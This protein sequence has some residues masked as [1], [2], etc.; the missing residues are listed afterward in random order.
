MK[1]KLLPIISGILFTTATM[2]SCLKSDTP[3]FE[4]IPDATI[5]AFQIDTV[6]GGI[7]KPFSIN[8]KAGLIFN[9]DSLPFGSDTVINKILIKE[10]KVNYTAV[11]KNDSILDLRDSLDLTKPLELTTK[12][13][14]DTNYTKKYTIKVNVHKQ[15][16]NSIDWSTI[17]ASLPIG[18]EETKFLANIKN[19][20]MAFSKSGK[21][22]TLENYKGNWKPVNT[23]DIGDSNTIV[24]VITTNDEK[25]IALTSNNKL[26]ISED[27]EAWTSS[28]KEL[29]NLLG[30]NKEEIFATN[31]NTLHYGSIQNGT[32]EWKE[33]GNTPKDF[34]V[35][36]ITSTTYQLNS[37][38]TMLYGEIESDQTAP[39]VWMYQKEGSWVKTA[40]AGV[41]KNSLPRLQNPTIF[42][43]NNM[44]YVLG[45]VKVIIKK[46]TEEKTTKEEGKEEETITKY[47]N[48]IYTSQDA[49]NWYIANSK[50]QIP[51]KLEEQ[52]IETLTVDNNNYIWFITKDDNKVWRGRLNKLG[53]K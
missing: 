28:E 26:Y 1:I 39:S 38:L 35:K 27:G 18:A 3:N 7:T 53:F 9:P 45:K 23:F 6:P 42:S 46:P 34:P 14:Y 33:K 5:H 51:T 40:D 52:I 41:N 20:V 43:Y 32:I 30:Y 2:M 50:E 49:I 15:D 37:N 21:A 31:N 11:F 25:I 13:L 36:N 44:L 17:D 12:N 29:S 16:P 48:K 4:I 8:Q 10:L 22:Y 19:K 47:I 24:Q